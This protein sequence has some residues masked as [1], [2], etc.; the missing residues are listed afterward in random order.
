MVVGLA[1][2]LEGQ[3]TVRDVVQVLQPLEE[4]DGDTTGVDVQIGNDQ[5]VAI[6]EDLVGSGGGG[7]VGSLG[8]DLK[9][10]KII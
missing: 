8:N 9:L 4:G 6:D 1:L 10:M 5:D 7:A 2:I 3:A